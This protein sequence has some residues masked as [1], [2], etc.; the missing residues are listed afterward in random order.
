MGVSGRL[1][2]DARVSQRRDADR[3][4]MPYAARRNDWNNH[5]ERHGFAV[6]DRP[7]R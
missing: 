6:P 2:K 7:G 4:A 3:T 5:V 1:G